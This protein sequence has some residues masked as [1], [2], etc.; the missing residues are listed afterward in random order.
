MSILNSWKLNGLNLNV[1]KELRCEF[2]FMILLLQNI[3]VTFSIKNIMA[4][5]AIVAWKYYVV[6]KLRHSGAVKVNG[7][8]RKKTTLN[9]TLHENCPVL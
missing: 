8:M 9:T 7:K 4:Y 1:T 5:M 3:K 6:L 2:Y